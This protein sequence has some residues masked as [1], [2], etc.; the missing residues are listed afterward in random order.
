MMLAIG[1]L[2]LFPRAHVEQQLEHPEHDFAEAEDT[3]AGEQTHG[4]ACEV[5]T[6]INLSPSLN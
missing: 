2:W 6:V 3:H 4:A 1:N 5:D